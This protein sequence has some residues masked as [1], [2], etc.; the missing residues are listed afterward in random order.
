M[1]LTRVLDV[2]LPEIPARTLAQTYPR[3]DPGATFREH[4]E[5][6]KPIFRIFIPSSGLMFKLPP[7]LWQL[8]QLFDGKRTYEQ[9]AELYSQQTGSAYDVDQVREVGQDLEVAQFW[10]KT[11]Q[12]KNILLMQQTSEERKKKL[13]TRSR[14]ADLSMVL[15]PA[16]N[17]DP[18]LTWLYRYTKFFYYP[19]VVA[20]T[21]LS[22][23]I[24]TGITIAHWDQIG[25]DTVEFYNF[26]N[27]TWGDVFALYGISMFIVVVHEFAHAHGCKHYGARVP[28]MGF[29]LV[30]L[31]PAFYTDTT[32]GVVM[33]NRSQR[34]VISLAGIWSELILC[35][36]AT[37]IWWGTP[38]DTAIHNGAYFIMM[39]TGIMSV[40]MNWNPLMK[41]DGYH[42][43]SEILGITDLKENSTAYVAGWVKRYLW[44]LPVEV[45]YVPK[46]R[47][48]GFVV[49]ALVSGVYSY[50]VLYVVARFAGNIVRNFSPEWGFV[51]EIAVALMI[52]RSRIRLLVNFMK[53]V[54][55]D[56]KDRIVAWFTLQ[57]SLLVGGVL[58]ALLAI[59]IWHDSVTGKF[60]LEPKDSAIV[61]ASVPGLLS[62]IRV[63]EGQR[64]TVGETLGTLRNVPLESDY[65][66]A[67]A[68]LMLASERSAS[69]SLHYV[70]YG[71]LLKEQEHL[72]R[73]ARY[74]AERNSLLNVKSPISG[75]VL[76]PRVNQQ[77]GSYFTEGAP[78]AEIGDPSQMRARIYISEYELSK[79]QSGQ[80]AL[81]Q[82]DG[83]LKRWSGKVQY[84]STSATEMDPRLLGEVKLKGMN[85]PHYYLVDIVLQNPDGELKPGMTGIARVYGKRKSLLSSGWDF[86]RDF[87]SRK[88][89]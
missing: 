47:R 13:Q 41:L 28:A 53:F 52:F 58:L 38:P 42:M 23:A 81:A 27:K 11:P 88:L 14:W 43:L 59:P 17:P 49:Y 45:P 87:W 29:A 32:E 85:P 74:L 67:R 66:H 24:T 8:V 57:H 25:R 83:F 30:Y 40:I 50:L 22:F 65:E 12:Q 68:K 75:V 79:I 51:P 76:T 82:V 48:F 18:I 26:T 55:L 71:S 86:A 36:I 84:I 37:P 19:W 35:A 72:D 61:R 80:A 44:R 20:L 63:K 77:L 34:L 78:L 4:I 3:L 21:L 9:V 39:L 62:E 73:E 70:D 46:S 33:A 1:N 6:G 7:E 56:K 69:A 31:T 5:E 54:Y 16:F 10:Y 15:F 60:V 89:W 64:V 2:A